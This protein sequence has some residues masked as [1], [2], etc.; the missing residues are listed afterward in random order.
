MTATATAA[1]DLVTREGH[2]VFLTLSS[3]VTAI[4]HWPAKGHRAPGYPR[5]TTMSRSAAIVFYRRLKARAL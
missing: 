3:Q 4:E 2:W 5:G 1:A